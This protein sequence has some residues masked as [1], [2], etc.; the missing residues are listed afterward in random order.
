MIT[1]NSAPILSADLA[2]EAHGK[3]GCQTVL[4]SNGMLDG[5]TRWSA[6]APAAQPALP[7]GT[8]CNDTSHVYRIVALSNTK[9]ITKNPGI[10]L[11]TCL[12]VEVS[13]Q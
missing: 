13:F 4:L 10:S 5:T 11:I 1:N 7:D 12:K 2:Y 3:C 9:F 8:E 6:G